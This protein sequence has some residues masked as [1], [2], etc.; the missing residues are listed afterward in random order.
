MVST[1]APLTR[2]P[3]T[4]RQAAGVEVTSFLTDT[5]G[6]LD[7]ATVDAFGV[8]WERFQQF[9]DED[10][11]RGGQEYF[12]GLLPDETLKGA[13]VLDL[14]CG[15]GRWTRYFAKRAGFVEAADPSDAAFVAARA[16]GAL[17]NV[18]VIQASVAGLPYEEGSF[19]VVASVGVLHHVPDTAAAIGTLAPLLRPGGLMYLYL[20]YNLED[21]PWHFR[22]AFAASNVLR[23]VI[24]RLPRALKLAACDVAAVTIYAPFVGLASIVKRTWPNSRAHE[25]VPL[26]AYVGKPWKIIRNDALDRLGTPLERRFS[27]AE[28]TGMLEKSGLTD[29]RFGDAMPRWR[30]VARKKV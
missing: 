20:Y 24:S 4:V 18:R 2:P 3:R 28:I 13:R 15:S 1:A 26:H 21:R 11:E 23:Q 12:A 16:T 8:E 25:A 14:G 5:E 19:D 9:S 10:V 22:A 6:N 30:V 27:R 7:R 17:S 29:V